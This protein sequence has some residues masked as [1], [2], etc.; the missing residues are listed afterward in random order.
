ML[1]P[2]R[3]PM[4]QNASFY[5]TAA[6]AFFA[7]LGVGIF[8]ESRDGEV[9]G[10]IRE[11]QSGSDRVWPARRS[12]GRE[13]R[14]R[15]HMFAWGRIAPTGSLVRKTA[16]QAAFTVVL[17][18]TFALGEI[19]CLVVL[20]NERARGWQLGLISYSLI[21]GLVLTIGRSSGAVLRWQVPELSHRARRRLEVGVMAALSTVAGVFL[22]TNAINKG[23]GFG[24]FRLPQ[25]TNAFLVH[26]T[27]A[28][29][30][31]GL[32]E[33]SGPARTAPPTGTVFL[34]NEVI[35]ISCQVRGGSFIDTHGSRSGVWDRLADGGY[36]TD[37]FVQTPGKGTFSPGVQR[38]PTNGKLSG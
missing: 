37:V 29:G 26:G 25:T 36:V 13:T 7:L 28:D 38:C 3:R 9:G 16:Q 17:G 1:W 14:P 32:T 22:V 11:R 8:A 18:G 35:H 4:L 6:T 5:Q 10:R 27:C 33:R 34:D 19:L 21:L 20:A 23:T 30:R 31:C 12:T 24:S 15:R 2:T